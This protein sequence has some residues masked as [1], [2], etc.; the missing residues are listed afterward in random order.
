[1]NAS[2]HYIPPNR[3]DRAFN[4]VV[5]GLARLGVNLAGAETLT[6]IG[7]KTGRPQEIPVNPLTL[8]DDEFL[9]AVRGETQWVRNVRATAT[10]EL[11][12]GRR[13]R[14][15]ILEEVAV[16]DRAPIIAAYLAKWGWEVG[17]FL[18]GHLTP[19]ASVDEIAT[20]AAKLPVFIVR[21]AG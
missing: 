14:R 10:V 3:F 15:V 6:V 7:R 17:R 13:V 21:P 8:D 12:R 2:T 19:G 4:A 9:V 18:P 1:M 5:G 11:R 20:E 16:A